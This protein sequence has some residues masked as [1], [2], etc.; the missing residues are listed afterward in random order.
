[1]G[2][3]TLWG[4]YVAHIAPDARQQDIAD[5]IGVNQTTISRWLR[6]EKTP[7]EAGIIAALA[8][9]YDKNPIQA[10][11]AAGVLT[12]ADAGAALSF[13]E[14]AELEGLERRIREATTPPRPRRST[15]RRA[16]RT[17]NRRG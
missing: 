5:A 9:H 2:T 4:A 14:L 1:M 3:M 13:D 17:P 10:F 7:D 15:S 12:V 8:R 11:V 6:G 16:A